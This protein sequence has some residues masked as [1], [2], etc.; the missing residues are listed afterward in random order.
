[1]VAL[2]TTN[3]L[4]SCH[5]TR[6]LTENRSIKWTLPTSTPWIGSTADHFGKSAVKMMLWRDK[7]FFG[8]AQAPRRRAERRNDDL[9][10]RNKAMIPPASP[11]GTSLRAFW[12]RLLEWQCGAR[13]SPDV[14]SFIAT[15]WRMRACS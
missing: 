2:R 5:G 15:T 14:N 13:A 8:L 12:R 11:Q 3:L 1:V 9:K 4:H 7:A 6:A 10:A